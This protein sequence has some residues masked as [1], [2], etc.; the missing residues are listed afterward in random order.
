MIVGVEYLRQQVQGSEE[1]ATPVHVIASEAVRIHIA[2]SLCASSG[3]A[4]SEG[5]SLP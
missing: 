4:I 1:C 3:L 2:L 5:L